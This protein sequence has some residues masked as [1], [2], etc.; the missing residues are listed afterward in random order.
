MGI[1]RGIVRFTLI[2]GLVLGG[3]TLL[4]G[5]SRMAAGLDSLRAKAQGVID[6]CVESDN[7]ETLRRE[8]AQLA[9]EYPTWIQEVQGELAEVDHQLGEFE[10]DTELSARVIDLTTEDFAELKALVDRAEHRENSVQRVS[11]RF[12]GVRFGV[13]EAY[14]E[15]ARI[16]HVRGSYADRLDHNQQQ[17]KILTTQRS[18]LAQVLDK[19]ET[20]YS[21]LQNHVWQLD[22]QIDAIERNDR[23]I[24]MTEKLQ[25][26][27]ES[28][29]KYSKAVN[30][31]Q[32]Q[33]KLAEL[34]RQQEAQLETLAKKTKY[35]DYENR[36]KYST[37]D[38]AEDIGDPL[39]QDIDEITSESRSVVRR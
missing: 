3:L 21:T 13:D 38:D 16:D 37:N 22:R 20:E 9:D 30:L 35:K 17:I 4:I 29:D 23:L 11:I 18:R 7:P 1:T 25:A 14:N 5:P 27:V 26:T 31:K 15:L 36:A 8:L 33:S 32:I 28:Y 39:I 12:D 6:S 34:R 24:V 2:G 10:H 19:L